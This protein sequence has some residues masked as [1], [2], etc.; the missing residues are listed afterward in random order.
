MQAIV[1]Y[2]FHQNDLKFNEVHLYNAIKSAI[3]S[4]IFTFISFVTRKKSI[5]ILGSF[6]CLSIQIF[7]QM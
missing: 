2:A 3:I 4:Q 5:E 7:N 6:R 1:P